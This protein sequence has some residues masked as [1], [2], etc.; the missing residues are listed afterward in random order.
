MLAPGGYLLLETF[1]P[2]Q[3]LQGYKSGGPHD[4]GMMFSLHELR[5]LLRPYPGQELE[6][7]ELD[8]MLHEGAYHEGMGAVVRFVWQKAQ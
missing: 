1:R 8:Y 4:P 2:D 5:Q 7:E 3:R 6:S